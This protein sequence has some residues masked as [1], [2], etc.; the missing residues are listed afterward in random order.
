[1]DPVEQ[2]R[3]FNRSVTQRIGA[4]DDHF[5]GRGRA[6][7]AS[8]LLFEIGEHGAGGASLAYLRSRLGLDSGYVS[9]LLRALE[10]EDLIDTIRD[11]VDRRA[12][13]AVLTVAGRRELSELNRRSD[14]GAAE[15]LA[16]LSDGQRARLADAMAEVER[17]LSASATIIE[18]VDPTGAEARWCLDRYFAELGDRFDAGFDP[19][20]TAPADAGELVP[21]R[22][23]FLVARLDGEPVACGAV[24]TWSP[25]IGEIK[26]MWVAPRV[27]GGGLGARMLEALE[28]EAG[29]LGFESVRLET[30]LALQEAQAMYRAHG[31]EAIE[32]FSGDPYADYGFERD[33]AA[34]KR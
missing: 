16:P 26:R 9:R 33:L 31:Y 17:L 18:R 6:L 5:L 32:P 25:G 20:L 8:R 12:R 7:G 28:Q 23:A 30:N 13:R 29:E 24:K 10:G 19:Q 11:P 22:G 21:P 34:L 1:M 2:I 4:L 15:L 3:S 27:R 14:D